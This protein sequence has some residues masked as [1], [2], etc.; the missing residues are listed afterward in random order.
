MFHTI[1]LNFPNFKA[2]KS[3]VRI[4]YLVLLCLLVFVRTQIGPQSPVD[5][6]F[7]LFQKIPHRTSL[8]SDSS[9]TGMRL[10]GILWNLHFLD[11]LRTFRITLLWF[12][13][14]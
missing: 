2:R 1:C 5:I 12:L 14:D 4:N 8:T 11:Y 13:L 3:N 6:P 10:D 7:L 9:T